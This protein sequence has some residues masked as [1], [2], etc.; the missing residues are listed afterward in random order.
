MTTT[1][2]HPLAA[3]PASTRE[4]Q[5]LKDVLGH[6]PSG[7]T[8][9]TAMDDGSPA[10]FSCQ[11]FHSLS[12]DPPMIMLL[13]GRTSTS[14]P[15]MRP[16]GRFCVNVLADGQAAI[17][18]TFAISG[19]DKFDGVEWTRS[20]GGSPVLAGVN[21]W[22]DCALQDEL[23]GGDHLIVTG[24]VR[25]FGADESRTPLVFHRGAFRGTTALD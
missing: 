22:I 12:L 9:V 23:D 17:C 21:A 8:I 24:R 11:S 7:V 15:R 16:G 4:T 18:R 2:T 19:A 25:G 10:G 3:Q 13:V 1:M 5:A 20:P 6:Y 14:W